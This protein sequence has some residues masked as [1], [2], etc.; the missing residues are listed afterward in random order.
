MKKFICLLLALIPLSNWPQ[1]LEELCK[2]RVDSNEMPGIAVATIEEGKSKF[3]SYGQSSLSSHEPVTSKTLF[4][5]GS[6]TKTFTC[7]VLAYLAQKHEVAL[8][9][10]AQKHLPS[11]ILLPEKNKKSI[12]LLHLASAHSGLPRMPGN[13]SPVD[14]SNPYIDYTE[15]ELTAYL[16]NCELKYE[17]GTT[18]EY[19]NLGMGLLGF[20]LTQ[21]KNK[22]YSQLIKEIILS[23]LGMNQTFISGLEKSKLLATGY[24]DNSPT[25][26]WT[27]S[28]QSVLTGAGGIVSNAEDMLKF[29]AAQLNSDNST[30]T[31]AF[32]EA[33]KERNEA[34]DT[35]MQIGLG[36]HIRKHKYIWH[37]GGTG[38]FRSFIGFDPVKKRGIVI[39]TNSTTGADD[40]GFHWL[41]ESVPLK[42]VKKQISLDPTSLKEYEG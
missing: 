42:Q 16:N 14:Q 34:G 5:I 9:D 21:E 11:S 28:N 8:T 40:L 17:P 30:L 6:V 7:S 25:K 38:G 18:Y 23:P 22:P 15:K 31:S 32:K 39:L 35:T 4:E 29:V 24:R 27:W 10:P 13:F 12:T 26:A 20:I 37:N 33:H 1:S 19:S 41:D 2:Q 36:W 3:F